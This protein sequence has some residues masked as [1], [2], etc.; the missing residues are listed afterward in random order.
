MPRCGGSTTCGLCSE[1]GRSSETGARPGGAILPGPHPRRGIARLGLQSY[2]HSFPADVAQERAGPP[3]LRF[4][5]KESEASEAARNLAG[6]DKSPRCLRAKP[7]RAGLG[8]LPDVSKRRRL[9][10]E[11]PRGFAG[12]QRGASS[13]VREGG[14][15]L[16]AVR[17]TESARPGTLWVRHG[18]KPLDVIC[19]NL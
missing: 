9:G 18:W 4:R 14:L 8:I 19:L 6:G 10:G 7:C 16:M 12:K 11:A 2:G 5:H 17:L 13:S 1:V 3:S 15:L